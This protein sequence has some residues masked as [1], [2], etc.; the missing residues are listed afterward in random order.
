MDKAALL[1]P[2]LFIMYN[3]SEFNI[4]GS[5]KS[6]EQEVS[7]LYQSVRG[8]DPRYSSSPSPNHG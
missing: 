5:K 8:A 2:Y 3:T 6:R 4:Q 7:F 1:L